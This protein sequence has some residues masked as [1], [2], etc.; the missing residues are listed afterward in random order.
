MRRIQAVPSFSL[1]GLL[2][3]YGCA[4]PGQK[5]YQGPP[6]PQSD[7]ATVV[8]QHR[9]PDGDTIVIVFPKMNILIDGKWS[10][11]GDGSTLLPGTYQATVRSKCTVT[12]PRGQLVFSGF[13]LKDVPD[14]FTVSAGQ[15]VTYFLLP[16]QQRT[17]VGDNGEIFH[18]ES[19]GHTVG[20][21]GKR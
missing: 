2:W 14:S 21:P 5:L 11:F 4:T 8:L 12:A 16:H 6:K 10:E 3:L 15:T 19:F 9:S 13:G 7:I 1:C 17:Y 18:C 20:T